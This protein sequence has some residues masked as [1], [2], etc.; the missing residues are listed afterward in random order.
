[1]SEERI[2]NILGSRLLARI[3]ALATLTTVLAAA[4]VGAGC[5]QKGPLYLPAETAPPPNHT[6]THAPAAP[7]PLPASAP[8]STPARP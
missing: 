5:G 6:H 2:A 4:A 1:M 8:A 7:A 3:S